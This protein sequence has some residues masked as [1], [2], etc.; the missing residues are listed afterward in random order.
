MKIILIVFVATL[1]A[2]GIIAWRRVAARKYV[3]LDNLECKDGEVTEVKL[4][5]LDPRDPTT[6]AIREVAQARAA[7]LDGAWVSIHSVREY[8]RFQAATPR[9]GEKLIVVDVT[10][11][12]YGQ[13]F[14]LDGV[15]L[16][17]VGRDEVQSCGGDAHQVYLNADGTLHS[18]Q[19]DDYWAAN[20]D[21]CT[22]RLYLV[23][24][25]P[26]PVR[27]IGLGY[28]GRMLMKCG[29]D[30]Q[31]PGQP[32]S[33]AALDEASVTIHSAAEYD[34]FRGASPQPGEKL[35]AV[36]VTFSHFKDGFTLDGVEL[37]DVGQAE[38]QS[39][40]GDAYQVY[41]NADGTL[42]PQ[43]G[44]DYWATHPNS[45]TVRLYLVYSVPKSVRRIGL[46]YW[47][48]VIVDR[49]YDVQLPKQLS[50]TAR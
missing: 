39:C 30:V 6:A 23:Y 14:T 44:D 21:S 3:D 42:H 18:K 20:P 36:D 33:A 34:Q 10:F 47:E 17:D 37:L 24:S 19:G 4:S 1:V 16:L 15:E 48:R 41:L 49:R 7:A 50:L 40:G 45:D 13:G 31:L 12:D 38:V 46:G 5:N 8:D 22:V 25:A 9:P 32:P 11:S 2:A 29:Y 27:K 26:K 35:V 43:Q 28:W